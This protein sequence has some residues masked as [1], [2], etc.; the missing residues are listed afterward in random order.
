MKNEVLNKRH[1]VNN[2]VMYSNEIGSRAGVIWHLLQEKG[3]LS[4]RIIGELIHCKESLINL[5]LGW[6]MR[7]DKVRFI[8]KEGTTYVELNTPASD[9]YY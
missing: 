9:L 6:L 4:V 7:E 8:E 1:T 5:S 3:A 2:G